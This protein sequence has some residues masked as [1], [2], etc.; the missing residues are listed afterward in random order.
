MAKIE[1]SRNEGLAAEREW[2]ANLGKNMQ[3]VKVDIGEEVRSL[4]SFVEFTK[5]RYGDKTPRDLK[6][7]AQGELMREAKIIFT[8]FSRMQSRIEAL[9]MRDLTLEKKVRDYLLNRE[10]G[11]EAELNARRLK[12]MMA[13]EKEIRN[14]L[15]DVVE[16]WS[17]VK[18]TGKLPSSFLGFGGSKLSRKP[19]RFPF[20][21]M[22]MQ[23][24]HLL[25]EADSL[26][27]AKPRMF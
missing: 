15:K 4:K 9:L 19:V 24:L 7:E 17:K 5:S 14:E 25:A 16:F 18:Y 13:E 23:D 12:R 27:N 8:Q 11:P 1:M 22:E 2:I 20:E 26:L 10:L 21:R 3:D 6:N